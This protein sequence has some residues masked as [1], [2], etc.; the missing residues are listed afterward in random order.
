MLWW[1]MINISRIVDTFIK[2]RKKSH[3]KIQLPWI[4]DTIRQLMKQRDHALKTFLKTRHEIDLQ[5]FKG[6][7]NRVTKEFRTLKSNYYIHILSEAKGNGNIME[8]IN[9]LIKPKSKAQDKYIL[10]VGDEIV[11]DSKRIANIF[12]DFFIQSVKSCI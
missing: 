7:R 4:N 9:S 1:I 6:L 8:T 5:L 10:K 2:C 3:R 11:H 12:N